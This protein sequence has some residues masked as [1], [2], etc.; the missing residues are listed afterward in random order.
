MRGWI[1][2]GV[3]GLLGCGSAA[4][5]AERAELIRQ[6][7]SLVFVVSRARVDPVDLPCGAPPTVQPK[8]WRDA[9]RALFAAARDREPARAEAAGAAEAAARVALRADLDRLAGAA[10]APPACQDAIAMNRALLEIRAAEEAWLAAID[11]YDARVERGETPPEPPTPDHGAALAE[12]RPLLTSAHADAATYL[13]GWIQAEAGRLEEA[14]TTFGLIADQSPRA[15]EVAL[16][17][18]LIDADA[19]LHERAV[20][21]FD[22]AIR[23]DREDRFVRIAR[24]SKA[25]SQFVIGEIEPAI[26]A[27]VALAADASTGPESARTAG[28]L[29]AKPWDGAPPDAA[30]LERFVPGA[31]ASDARVMRRT[32]EE[33]LAQE[34]FALVRTLSEATRDRFANSVELPGILRAWFTSLDHLDPPAALRARAQVLAWITPAWTARH[35][36]DPAAQHAASRLVQAALTAAAAGLATA[37]PPAAEA[38]LRAL[39]ARRLAPEPGLRLQLAALLSTARPA[40]AVIEYAQAAAEGAPRDAAL[41][42]AMRAAFERV[43]RDDPRFAEAEAAHL[44]FAASGEP[45]FARGTALIR[46]R[47]PGAAAPHFVAAADAEPRAEHAP[48]A[49]FNAAAATEM[50][51]RLGIARALYARIVAQYPKS[52]LAEQSLFVLGALSDRV[53]DHRAALEY[54][55]R[56]AER[57]REGPRAFDAALNHHT[58]LTAFERHR[59]AGEAAE[60][61]AR[62]APDKAMAHRL[63]FE[64]ARA[65]GRAGDGQRQRAILTALAR[66]RLPIDQRVEVAR[67]LALVAPEAEAPRAWKALAMLL[68]QAEPDLP[69]RE[70]R[71]AEARFALIE[72]EYRAHMARALS[73]P[74]TKL[75]AAIAQETKTVTALVDRY[76]QIVGLRAPRWSLAAIYRVGRLYE[77]FADLIRTAPP[78][79]GLD[80]TLHETYLRALEA[81]GTPL[82]ARAIEAYGLV[83]TR[84]AE[85]GVLDGWTAKARARLCHLDRCPPEARPLPIPTAETLPLIVTIEGAADT[86]AARDA[87]AALAAAA[88]RAVAGEIEAAREAFRLADARHPGLIEAQIDGARLAEWAG[89][90]PT[91]PSAD[92]LTVPRAAALLA[93]DEAHAALRAKAQ[94]TLADPDARLRLTAAAPGPD[95]AAETLARLESAPANPRARANRLRAVLADHPPL[96]GLLSGREGWTALEL[97]LLAEAEVRQIAGSPTPD[98]HRMQARHL[99]DRAMKLPGGAPAESYARAAWLRLE[100]GDHR[101]AVRLGTEAIRRRPGWIPARLNL[102]IAQWLAGDAAV[103]QATLEAI[104]HPVAWLNLGLMRLASGDGANAQPLLARYRDAIGAAIDPAFEGWWARATR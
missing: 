53:L 100:V 6:A 31:T 37:D 12:L 55:A 18:G 83:L 9:Q 81:H 28:F 32:L 44:P 7:P 40:E 101:E 5:Q 3:V 92:A 60:A 54:F 70:D 39:L 33:L 95:H 59:E 88:Q 78:P 58:L 66:D 67:E 82:H 84:S 13:I 68:D 20:A 103:G 97:D 56:A 29:L 61:L 41:A 26:D 50:D 87:Q 27:L 52:A 77:R 49:L 25:R 74:H 45:P 10:A 47:H 34:A 69:A 51:G 8:A 64:A 21:A 73:L 62:R 79:P 35:A 23:F 96:S 80:P 1:A 63:R 36:R 93:W 11:A 76:Q 22:R 75:A 2:L 48:T 19:G 89:E 42:A 99:L 24:Y 46:A 30:R 86:D 91:R 57:T 4:R 15:A 38:S 43:A 17:I 72:P 14:R 65:F 16:R 90:A 85:L 94:P 104:D 71:L 102:G 98:L